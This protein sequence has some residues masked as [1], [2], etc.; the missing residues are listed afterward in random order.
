[1]Q[2]AWLV[3]ALVLLV[4]FRPLGAFSFV[5]AAA[6]GVVLVFQFATLHFPNRVELTDVGVT[7]GGYG[8]EHRFAWSEVSILAVRRFLTGDRVLVRL[9]PTSPWR[10]RYWL[11]ES[12]ENYRELV[13]L[14]EARAREYALRREP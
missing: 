5:L 4:A 3:G 14:L 10:G 12:L 9:G 1:M 8:R 6:S 13:A 7:F 2:D 11:M